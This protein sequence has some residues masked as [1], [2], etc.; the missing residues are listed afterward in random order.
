MKQDRFTA[1]KER[2]RGYMQQY[3]PAFVTDY[4]RRQCP[5]EAGQVI[6]QAD[7]LMGQTFT[8]EDRWDME[9]CAVPY[10]LKEMIWDYSPNQDPEWIF[11]LNRHEY[12]HKLL[13]AYRLTGKQAYIEKLEWYMEHWITSNPILPEGT[14]TTRSIDTGIRCMSWQF[15]LIHLIG[16]G[17]M[18]QQEA[19]RILDSMRSQ[20]SYMRNGYIGKYTLSNWGLLQTAAICHGFLWFGEYLPGDGLMEWAWNELENQLALQ[21][22]PD[23][24]H[25]EQSMMYHM[26]VLMSCMKLLAYWNGDVPKDRTWLLEKTADMSRYAMYAAGPDHCQIAQCDSDITDVRDVLTKAAVL[27]GDGRFRFA[28]FESMDLD[29]AWLLGRNGICRYGRQK[30][31]RPEF[32]NLHAEDTGN[33]YVR[34]SWS[35]DSHFTYLTCG[36]LGSGHGHADLTHI[37]LY[38]KGRPF[39]VDSGR[40][41]YMEEEP[42]R[43]ALKSAQAHNVCVVD[44][45]SQGIPNGS[46]GYDSY[47]ECLK[48]YYREQGP[49]QY[50]EM[51]YHGMLSSGQDC[52]VIRRV[53]MADP[54]IWLI[55]NDIGCRGRHVV[56]E[57]YHMDP[58]VK[59][60]QG[61][62]GMEGGWTLCSGN[63]SLNLLGQTGFMEEPCMISE[64][65]NQLL[66]SSCLVKENRFTDRHTD[67]TCLAGGDVAMG[68][69]PVYQY[70]RP[71]PVTETEVVSRTFAI[72]PSESWVFLIWNQETFKGGKMYLCNGIPIYAKAAALHCRN[73]NT[74]LYRLRN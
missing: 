2:T 46:W 8:F 4:M 58:R 66:P 10:T 53:L 13:L 29:S 27:T 14:V 65:Y 61:T 17:L 57:Y 31:R 34:N 28:G 21:V 63:I 30:P 33:V 48:T 52:L 60:V 59:A 36:P 11:M 40:Y 35:E 41:S 70:G 12:L 56:Q 42:L 7:R 19:E 45:E 71:Q 23:G 68:S 51:A 47:G 74:T 38:Y 26:E 39:L 50:C 24:S 1:L 69:A 18:G 16:E 62:Q 22:L 67:W 3:D 15:L 44:G 20:F 5:L 72:S 73:G 64:T 32:K 43:P 25:W 37:S 6:A 54:G 49:V 9:P 55:V